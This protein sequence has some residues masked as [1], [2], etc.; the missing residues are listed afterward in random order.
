MAH[1]LVL[2]SHLQKG[3]IDMSFTKLILLLILGSSLIGCSNETGETTIPT[4]NSPKQTY[5]YN[6][7]TSTIKKQDTQKIGKY[8]YIKNPQQAISIFGDDYTYRENLNGT[9]SY[10][11]ADL[12]IMAS[13]DRKGNFRIFDY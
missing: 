11:W 6:T 9:Y 1:I 4:H 3:L 13:M 7:N 5:S 10:N 12:R 2:G 8:D